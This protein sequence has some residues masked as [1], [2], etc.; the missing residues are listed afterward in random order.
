VLNI[1]TARANFFACP[2]RR[3]RKDVTPRDARANNFAQQDPEA[4][5]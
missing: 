2:D 3:R 1:D 4:G 5:W